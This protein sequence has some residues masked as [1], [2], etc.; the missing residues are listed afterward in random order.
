MND[1]TRIIE[2][3]Q[4]QDRPDRPAFKPEWTPQVYLVLQ[5]DAENNPTPTTIYQQD[6][7]DYGD[8]IAVC[9]L[10]SNHRPFQAYR[11]V[12]G[13]ILK[14]GKFVPNVSPRVDGYRNGNPE[15]A[16]DTWWDIMTLLGEAKKWQETDAATQA[17]RYVARSAPREDG[18]KGHRQTGKTERNRA[19]GKAKPKAS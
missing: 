16:Q 15:V 13:T 18:A 11:F 4:K 8:A 9:C 14:S 2:E 6:L 19:R 5:A 3:N 12:L 10:M 1:V 7:P 17:D